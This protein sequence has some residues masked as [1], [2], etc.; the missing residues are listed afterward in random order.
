[1][2]APDARA[3]PGTAQEREAWSLKGEDGKEV[4]PEAGKNFVLVPP[5]LLI[6]R[7]PITITVGGGSSGAA[8]Q[9]APEEGAAGEEAPAP[10]KKSDLEGEG[11]VLLPAE[12]VAKLKGAMKANKAE[13]EEIRDAMATVK[14]EDERTAE[15]TGE[16]LGALRG[17]LEDLIKANVNLRK[18]VWLVHKVPGY[19]GRH[20]VPGVDGRDG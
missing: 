9:E 10:L 20:G 6:P 7:A 8:K 15:R 4:I 5:P 13:L 2:N 17:K 14:E 11:K 19:A 3:R 16:Q 12:D 1:M 18:D